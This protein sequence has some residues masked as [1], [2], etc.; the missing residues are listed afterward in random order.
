MPVSAL[1]SKMGY[2]KNCM[3]ERA[4]K[5]TAQVYTEE[6]QLAAQRAVH[7]QLPHTCGRMGPRG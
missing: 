4:T 3:I 5:T 2:V 6:R 1:L 7:L